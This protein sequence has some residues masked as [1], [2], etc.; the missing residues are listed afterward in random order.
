MLIVLVILVVGMSLFASMNVAARGGGGGG[1]AGGG[2]E[3]GEHSV[4]AG[5]EEHGVGTGVEEH[6]VGVGVAEHG[7]DWQGRNWNQNWWNSGSGVVF[8]PVNYGGDVNACYQ[9]CLASGQ[10]TPDQCAQTCYQTGY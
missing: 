7:A 5:V 4:G 9:A 6:G 10:Y 1:R 2:A 8:V 3:V